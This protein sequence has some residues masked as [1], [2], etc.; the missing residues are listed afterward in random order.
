MITCIRNTASCTFTVLSG[1]FAASGGAL[2]AAIYSQLALGLE[3]CILCLY[4]RMPFF[5]AM[6]LSV[7]GLAMQYNM[8]LVRAI[9]ALCALLFLANAGIATYHTGVE[10]KWWASAVEGCAVPDFNADPSLIEKI[11]TTPAASCSDIAWKDPL[12]GLTMANWNVMYCLAL[13]AGCL[14]SLQATRKHPV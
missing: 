1:I 10:L 12:F 13:F 2:F 5:V 11:M 4:Q 7:I 8:K 9:I 3:P 14:L 6:I